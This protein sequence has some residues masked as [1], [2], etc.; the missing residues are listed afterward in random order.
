MQIAIMIIISDFLIFFFFFV[1]RD[2][3]FNHS[4]I[5]VLAFLNQSF[6]ECISSM[7]I[8]TFDTLF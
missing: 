5:V 3:A 1:A 6:S 7:I 8:Y 4:K 2:N